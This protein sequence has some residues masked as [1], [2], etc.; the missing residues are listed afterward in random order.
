MSLFKQ[1][2]RI[3]STRLRGWDYSANAWYFITICTKDNRWFFGQV[4]N[5]QMVLSPVGKIVAEEWRR[6][7][8]LR[9]SVKLDESIIMPNHMHAIVHIRSNPSKERE[10]PVNRQE[11][12]SHKGACTCHT[13]SLGAIV[14]QFKAIC[15]KRIRKAG[16][17]DFAWQPRFFDHI[18]RNNDSLISK[19]DYILDNPSRWEQE[20]DNVENLDM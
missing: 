13:K 17:D 7:E 10:L 5:G 14:G 4:M 9:P 16:F 8:L 15:T 6:T 18:I 20:K 12:A 11:T 1:K 3:E 2:Y 19:R